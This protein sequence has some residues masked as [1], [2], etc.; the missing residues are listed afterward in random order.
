MKSPDGSWGR[1]AGHLYRVLSCLLHL[2]LSSSVLFQFC[3]EGWFPRSLFGRFCC[4]LAA[5][6][7]VGLKWFEVSPVLASPGT[8]HLLPGTRMTLGCCYYCMWDPGW[9]PHG[10]SRR[11]AWVIIV[12]V[13]LAPM[14][15][16][17][18]R[19]VLSECLENK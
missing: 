7:C 2:P 18:V 17:S 19:Q 15:G 9:V 16:P 13:T 14:T 12:L 8:M 10:A 3:F 6:F 1:M 5:P 11:W 4:P